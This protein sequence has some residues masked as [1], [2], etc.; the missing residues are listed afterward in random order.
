MFS[1]CTSLVNAPELPATTLISY[2]YSQMFYN[3]KA[4][5]YI[6]AMFTTT[7]GASYLSGWVSNVY[8]SGTFVKNSKAT[9]S[10][11]FGVN[12]IP[13]GWTVELADA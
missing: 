4:L 6:K 7:P 8:F 11:T 9:W 5:K 13:S 10:N 12:G 1:G 3:C 2:C